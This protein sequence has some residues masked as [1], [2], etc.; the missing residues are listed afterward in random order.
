[1]DRADRLALEPSEKLRN[2][3][4]ESDPGTY[5][6]DPKI[7]PFSRG[8]A[9][10]KPSREPRCQLLLLIA[11]YTEGKPTYFTQSRKARKGKEINPRSSGE[12]ILIQESRCPSTGLYSPR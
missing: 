4:T 8:C 12:H 9:A 11:G 5:E 3:P 10:K 6:I 2:E 7:P 1:M